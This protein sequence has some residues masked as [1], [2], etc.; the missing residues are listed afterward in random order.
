[1]GNPLWSLA[2]VLLV[3]L[4]S[5]CTVSTSVDLATFKMDR[6]PLD[7]NTLDSSIIPL[8]IG[9]YELLPSGGWLP[10]SGVK[11]QFTGLYST[12]DGKKQIL[13]G[14]V[15]NPDKAAQRNALNNGSTCGSE[16]GFA[17]P[18]PAAAIPYGYASCQGVAELNWI[19]GDWILSVIAY[20]GVDM[21]DLLAF[22]NRYSY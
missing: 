9:N 6:L 11:R 4:S 14:A 16:T 1:M 12:P 5:G 7:D 22:A 17:T 18:F 20:R 19:N 8:R 13:L 3:L 2:I 21:G 15:L 10:A